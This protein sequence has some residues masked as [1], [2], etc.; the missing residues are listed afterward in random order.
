MEF[1]ENRKYRKVLSSMVDVLI[2]GGRET[3]PILIIEVGNTLT[4]NK[5][6]NNIAVSKGIKFL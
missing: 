1:L 4:C 2:L 3:E 6:G 5:D